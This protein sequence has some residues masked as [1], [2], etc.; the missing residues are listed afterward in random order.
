MNRNKQRAMLKKRREIGFY[1][2]SGLPVVPPTAAAPSGEILWRG[3]VKV[4]YSV[5]GGEAYLV[6]NQSQEIKHEFRRGDYTRT[7]WNKLL[8]KLGMHPKAFW[9]AVFYNDGR[10]E[11][12]RR[13]AAEA[14]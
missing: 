9:Q 3:T 1:D 12:E 8:A 6:Y 11:F 14:W 5:A 10:I 4:Q 13:V 7:D 2:L